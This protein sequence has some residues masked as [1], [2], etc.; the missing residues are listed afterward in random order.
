MS[1]YTIWEPPRCKAAIDSE[2][3]ATVVAPAAGHS[4]SARRIRICSRMWW[5]RICPL[6]LG[7]PFKPE[8][9]VKGTLCAGGKGASVRVLQARRFR[10]Q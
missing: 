7:R 3:A 6:W 10:V 8:G 5:A 1:F 9:V 4:S 2:Q